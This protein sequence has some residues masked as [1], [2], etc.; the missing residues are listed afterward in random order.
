MTDLATL[1]IRF[2]MPIRSVW[3]EADRTIP[4]GGGR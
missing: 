2:P 3:D 1:E 4:H